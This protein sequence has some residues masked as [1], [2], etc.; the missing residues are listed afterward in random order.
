[1]LGFDNQVRDGEPRH[2][3]PSILLLIYNKMV[4]DCVDRHFQIPA[5]QWEETQ[6]FD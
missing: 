6:T 1:M 4:S 5:Q 3:F 2:R